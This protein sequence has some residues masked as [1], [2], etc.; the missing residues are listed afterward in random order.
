MIVTVA[1]GTSLTMGLKCGLT[2]KGPNGKQKL[3]HGNICG[4]VIKKHRPGE[5][6]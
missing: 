3:G 2:A 5:E 6:V 4:E 1:S